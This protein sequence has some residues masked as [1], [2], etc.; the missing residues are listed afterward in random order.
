MQN[1]MKKETN[2]HGACLACLVQLV[3]LFAVLGRNYFAIPT[4]YMST[5]FVLVFFRVL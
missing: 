4:W 5:I 3:F 1:H 2:A